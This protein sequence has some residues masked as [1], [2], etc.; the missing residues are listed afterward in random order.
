MYLRR[1]YLM[2]VLVINC[3]SSS[4]K[5]QLFNMENEEALAQGLVERIG[6]D[7]S[8]LKHKTPS[9]DKKVIETPMDN[10]RVALKNVLDA[11]VHEEYGA[12]DSLDEIE[13]VGHRVVHAG[14][15][16]SESVIVDDSV[17]EALKDCI[18]FQ[19]P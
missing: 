4:L 12:I 8:R 17:M 18:E 3:G 19:S 6:I 2:K 14:E 7:G 1:S 9:S 5:Y 16:Y 15:K 11:L 13:A 10:H